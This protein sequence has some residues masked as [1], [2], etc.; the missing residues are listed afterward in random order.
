[1]M[2]G[3]KEGTELAFCRDIPDVKNPESRRHKSRNPGIKIPRQKKSRIKG[4]KN[5]DPQKINL[6]PGDLNFSGFSNPSQDP[7]YVE[8]FGISHSGFFRNFQGFHISIALPG[9]FRF[10]PKFKVQIQKNPM[11]TP[12][13]GRK[14]KKLVGWALEHKDLPAEALKF[15]SF[16]FKDIRPNDGILRNDETLSVLYK[17]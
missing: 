12:T 5:F 16:F 6:D 11:S 9:I 8:I 13:L 17:F 2:N 15:A 7:R 4:I 14:C 10:S 1:M 3:E